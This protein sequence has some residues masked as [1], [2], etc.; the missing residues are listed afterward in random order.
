MEH[1]LHVH[2]IT[3]N[4]FTGNAAA[5]IRMFSSMRLITSG[6]LGSGGI[7]SGIGHPFGCQLDGFDD[8]DI[9]GAAA[10]IL[11]LRQVGLDLFGGGVGV[12]IQQPLGRHDHTWR[13]EAAL[14]SSGL[15]ER[16]LKGMQAAVGG[17]VLNCFHLGASH[18]R[19]F[20]QAGALG[21]A[22]DQHGAGPAM[23]G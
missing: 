20:H 2:V 14:H 1:A 21:F 16:A 5:R 12:F 10:M 19:H 15:H 11:V 7:S 9:A 4:K 22:I 6:A 8:L 17:E 18:A 3:V 23:P 13:A